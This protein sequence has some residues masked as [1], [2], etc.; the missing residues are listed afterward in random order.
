[1]PPSK[2][3]VSVQMDSEDP[4]VRRR[5]SLPLISPAESR[6]QQL[7]T[8]RLHLAVRLPVRGLALVSYASDTNAERSI[9]DA[10]STEKPTA[11]S[12]D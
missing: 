7:Q 3:G 6:L 4:V 5:L 9:V 11:S 1:M 12:D 10:A 2:H 8:S